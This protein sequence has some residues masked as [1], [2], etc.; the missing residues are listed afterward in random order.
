MKKILVVGSANMDLVMHTSRLPQPGE[1]IS[2]GRFMTA[3]GGKGANQAVAASR[4]GAAVT[5]VAC[6]GNDAFGKQHRNSLEHENIRLDFLKTDTSLPTGTA[7]ILITKSGENTIVVAPGANNALL[8][9]DIAVLEDTFQNADAVICQLE[10][11]LDTVEAVLRLSRK[12][13]IL[14]VLDTGP[15]C[16]LPPAFLQM[17][18]IVSPNENEAE[19]LTGIRVESLES[20]RLAAYALR[21]MGAVHVVLKLGSRGCLYVGKEE[22]YLPAFTIQAVDTTG[23][24]DA[25]TAALAMVWGTMPLKEAL[26]YANAAGALAATLAG[27]QPSMPDITAVNTFLQQQEGFSFAPN[28]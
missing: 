13:H 16:P 27:A 18:D 8:P 14:S 26:T 22:V 23:A 7:V 19:T 2:G 9:E 3:L 24:G 21:D 12:H 11:P 1:T 28:G 15:A 17:A 6:L 10:I 5:F 25:F 20:A 4:L